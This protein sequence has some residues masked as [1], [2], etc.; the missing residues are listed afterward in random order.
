MTAQFQKPEHRLLAGGGEAVDVGE[1]EGATGGVAEEG[2]GVA[3]LA[4]G[5]GGTE[6]DERSAGERGEIVQ[7]LDDGVGSAAGLAGEKGDAEVRREEAD[8]RP[9]TGHRRA[10][11]DE[12]LSVRPWLGRRDDDGTK[13]SRGER[14]ER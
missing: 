9:E 5:I 8:L 10:G 6:A 14:L 3:E 11:A 12:A 1:E 13:R 7:G 4:V 2:A